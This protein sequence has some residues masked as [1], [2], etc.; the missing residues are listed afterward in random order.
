MWKQSCFAVAFNAE[1]HLRITIVFQRC[2]SHMSVIETNLHILVIPSGILLAFC[3]SVN[4]LQTF[5]TKV[6]ILSS[7]FAKKL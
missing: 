4:L 6:V 7:I 2:P 3:V 5:T 1:L